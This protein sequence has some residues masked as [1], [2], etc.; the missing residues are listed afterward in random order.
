MTLTLSLQVQEASIYL[1]PLLHYGLM[2]YPKSFNT[3][4]PNAP[5][6]RSRDFGG[7]REKP[8]VNK[9]EKQHEI[10]L[11]G[12]EIGPPA[13]RESFTKGVLKSKVGKR[14]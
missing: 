11:Q 6:Y 2:V 1:P 9:A 14:M 3:S 4:H 10:Q 5:S 13:G 12:Q 7:F 8:R